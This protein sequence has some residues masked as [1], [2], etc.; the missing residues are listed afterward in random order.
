ML[1][2]RAQRERR[3]HVGGRP[4]RGVD[5]AGSGGRAARAT[6]TT[7]RR[8]RS[9]RGSSG[10]RGTRPTAAPCPARARGCRGP[11]WISTVALCSCAAATSSRTDGS[12][13]V[14]CSARGCSLMP[15]TP[16]SRQRRASATAPGSFGCTRQ[17]A[18]R[19][20]VRAGHRVHHGVVG[21]PCSRRA[22]ASG[23][24]APCAS[25]AASA[26]SSSSGVCLKP[27]GSFC[28]TCVWASN[29]VSAGTS[30]DQ[31][32]EPRSEDCVGVEHAAAHYC[33]PTWRR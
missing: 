10:R 1:L 4:P 20:P 19:R 13:S 30:S 26:S 15:L 22:R 33:P 21:R 31:P 14:N 7:G 12:E 2:G 5:V 28:P 3:Q 16:A 9:G 17:S 23:T 24:R 25:T 27:S 8:S 32:V 6:A 29:S 18:R 11:A